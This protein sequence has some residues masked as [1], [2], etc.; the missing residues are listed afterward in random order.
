MIIHFIYG[1]AI[2]CILPRFKESNNNNNNNNNIIKKINGWGKDKCD[3]SDNIT[4]MVWNEHFKRLLNKQNNTPSDEQKG[5]DTFP[6]FD[7]TLDGRI[8]ILELRETLKELKSG[9]APG[10]DGVLVEYLKLFGKKYENILHKII[11]NLFTSSI[12]PQQWHINFLKPIYKKGEHDN[13]NN[14]RGLAIG[15][16]FSKLFSMILLKRLTIFVNSKKLLSPNQIGFS[17]GHN[18]SDHIFLMQTLIEKV[19]KRDKRKLYTAFIDFKKAYDTVDREILFN[20]LKQLG[21]N[22]LFLKNITAMY[23]NTKYSIKLKNGHSQAL[24]SNLGLKQGCPLSPL[25]FNLYIDDINK[26]FEEQCDPITLQDDVLNHFL[27]ADDLVLLSSTPDGLQNCLNNLHEFSNRKC[28]TVSTN[29]SKTLVFNSA[30][31]FIKTTFR[32][33]QNVLEP[34]QNFCYLGFDLRASGTVKM[35]MNSLYD[36]AGK[37]LRPLMCVI[38]RFNLPFKISLKLFHTFITPILLYNVENWITM[39]DKKLQMATNETIFTDINNK[40]DILHR[41]FLKYILGTSKTC[42]N[43]MVYGET[44]EIPL[45]LK[46]FR[47]MV[48]YWQHLMNLPE[49]TL[50]KKALLENI[51]MRSNWIISIEKL[52]NW[53]NLADKIES[54]GRLKKA[55]Y[56]TTHSKFVNTWINQLNDPNTS[57]LQFYR[58]IKVNHSFEKYLE[59]P[60]FNDR[61]IIAKFRC[62]D[63]KLE[64]ESGRHNKTPQNERICRLCPLNEIENEEHFLMTCPLYDQIRENHGLMGMDRLIDI[65]SGTEPGRLGKYLNEAFKIRQ[66]CLDQMNIINNV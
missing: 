1:E 39:T 50:A 7:P 2:L 43:A 25:L 53:C 9:K 32:I 20:H 5:N 59:L 56:D 27:Y 37:A 26:I 64:I 51:Q 42:L 29:K 54:P 14:F 65:M 12:Y 11:N 40:C 15:S 62:S 49:Q 57:K 34:V 13:P 35:A 22:G 45:S 8:T 4:T 47:L 66:E 52:M 38:A 21:I 55:A 61:K 41:K 28:L 44:G 24:N 23:E 60:H 19:V 3:P 10:P 30:G 18:T 33:D 17:K 58:K 31:R 16:A 6:T 46:G 36:K 63:H 48:N